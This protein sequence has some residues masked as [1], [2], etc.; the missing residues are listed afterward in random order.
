MHFF[1]I[2]NQQGSVLII[3]LLILA[4]STIT[5]IVV[6]KMSINDLRS[7]SNLTHYKMA[8]YAAESGRNYVRQDP[9]LYGPANMDPDNPVSFESPAGIL[10]PDQSFDGTVQYLGKSPPPRGSGYDPTIFRAYKY[11]LTC[12]GYGPLKAKVT[13]EAG[14]YRVGY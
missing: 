12:N 8:F 11:K 13:I 14:F 1:R 5:G 6:A 10:G 4:L 3:V 7:S 2:K 9:S